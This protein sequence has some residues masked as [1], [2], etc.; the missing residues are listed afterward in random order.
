MTMM[1]SLPHSTCV[2]RV[3][4]SSHTLQRDSYMVYKFKG[5]CKYSRLYNELIS[6]F[7]AWKTLSAQ[8]QTE[9]LG[10]NPQEIYHIWSLI[11]K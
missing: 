4:A 10:K 9:N 1:P 11:D 8:L 7:T 5:K 6:T 3:S 2:Q